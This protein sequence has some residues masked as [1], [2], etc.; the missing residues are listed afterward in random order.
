[1]YCR[2]VDRRWLRA[3]S[4]TR[5]ACGAVLILTAGLLAAPAIGSTRA[6]A[7]RAKRCN[8]HRR[9]AK[10]VTPKVIVY[11]RPSGFDDYGGP[12]TKYYACLRPR[13]RSVAVG[14]SSIGGEY[15][16]NYAM[17]EL[18]VAGAFVAN[19]SGSGFA[20]E[21]ACDKYHGSPDCSQFVSWWLEVANARSRR[22]IQISLP[23]AA[24]PLAVSAAS[25]AAWVDRSSG[26]L[27]AMVLHPVG[28]LGFTGQAET[29]DT[30]AIAS[31]R[32]TGLTLHWTNAGQAK[33]QALG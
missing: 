15:P 27:H 22:T 6:D 33:S 17:L 20:D 3:A 19:L 9:H 1:M 30:G 21:T 5:V 25:A 29:L 16:G 4:A 2:D 32:F 7:A 23:G 14:R 24:R 13:G 18:R 26:T 10:R 12:V 31:L 11:G 28:G 8:A